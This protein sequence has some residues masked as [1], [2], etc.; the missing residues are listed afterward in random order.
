MLIR[1]FEIPRGSHAQG[2]TQRRARVTSTVAVM[3]ALAAEEEAVEAFILADGMNL[4]P[5]TGQHFVDVSLVGD[6]K[7]KFVL[8]SVKHPM[9][10]D[11]QLHDP[12]IGTEVSTRE[13]ERFNECGADLFNK[14]RQLFQ[15]QGFEISGA[16]NVRQG[17]VHVIKIRKV[18]CRQYLQQARQA[19]FFELPGQDGISP[20]VIRLW[21]DQRR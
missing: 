8:G 11:G 21:Q 5:A 1:T 7:D 2:G 17:G 14:R 4:V 10:G 19:S 9:K 18:G 16:G 20:P 13:A 3:L 12:E 15:R 6:I